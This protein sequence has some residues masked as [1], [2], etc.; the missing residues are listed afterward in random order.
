[1][2][3]QFAWVWITE[4]HLQTPLMSETQCVNFWWVFCS[5]KCSTQT[6]SLQTYSQLCCETPAEW[7]N[8]HFWR[9]K[10]NNKKWLNKQHV[11]TVVIHNMDFFLSEPS[12]KSLHMP[13]SYCFKTKSFSLY[14]TVTT[15][16]AP[17][18]LN[19]SSVRQDVCSDWLHGFRCQT[20]L[21]NLSLQHLHKWIIL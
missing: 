10:R 13:T 16:E 4:I 11:C 2:A 8:D 19:M 17:L 5:P 21:H 6:Q 18:K 15:D 1:M 14:N 7:H 9:K 12:K 20:M 3:E